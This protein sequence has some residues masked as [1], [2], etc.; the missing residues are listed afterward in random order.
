VPLETCVT[1]QPKPSPPHR[2]REENHGQERY[3]VLF[4]SYFFLFLIFISFPPALHQILDK[5]RFFL[6]YFR[7]GHIR[8]MQPETLMFLL[9][10]IEIIPF[11]LFLISTSITAV[12][13]RDYTQGKRVSINLGNVVFYGF[14]SILFILLLVVT[15]EAIFIRI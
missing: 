2:G 14:W 13:A 9:I 11:V 5:Y 10:L 8:S 4:S 7:V 15:F 12:S 6:L 1:N 3:L